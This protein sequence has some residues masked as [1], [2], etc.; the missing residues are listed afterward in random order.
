MTQRHWHHV[1]LNVADNRPLHE[2]VAGAVRRAIGAVPVSCGVLPA[3]EQVSIVRANLHHADGRDADSVTVGAVVTVVTAGAA[4]LVGVPVSRRPASPLSWGQGPRMDIPAGERRVWL[5]STEN[6]WL[7]LLSAVT[8]VG[9]LAAL[10]I[11]LG[12]LAE[13]MWLVTVPFLF[14]SVSVPACSS[15][16]VRVTSRGRDVV[17]GPLGW[18]VRRRDAGGHRVGT[19]REPDTG[20]P[21][22][23]DTGAGRR[24]GLPA[25]AGWARR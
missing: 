13:P 9:A 8:G 5:A 17:F 7:Y 22:H 19:G 21:G 20:T 1:E 3:G 10:L 15:V 4:G 24:L 14:A 2:Q 12:N 23:R 11:G 16:R 6:P 18:P 25:S